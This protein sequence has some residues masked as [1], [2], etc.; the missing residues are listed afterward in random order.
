M[1]GTFDIQPY[2]YSVI[3]FPIILEALTGRPSRQRAAQVLGT[4][5]LPSSLL[6]KI[7]LVAFDS[8]LC[9]L[10]LLCRPVMNGKLSKIWVSLGCELHRDLRAGWW[11]FAEPN[12]HHKSSNFQVTFTPCEQVSAQ[13]QVQPSSNAIDAFMSSVSRP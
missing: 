7:H 10:C 2:A 5:Y 9:E 3:A 13:G 6:L 1:S 11:C 4:T 8:L 12:L